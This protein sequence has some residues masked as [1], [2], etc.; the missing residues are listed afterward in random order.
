MVN[1]KVLAEL[2][3]RDDVAQWLETST[4]QLRLLLY[5]RPVAQRYKRFTLAKRR[6][7]RRAILAPPPDLK[8][9]QR[10][11]ATEL[12]KLYPLRDVVYGFA[13]GRSIIDNAKRHLRRRHVLN[14]DLS[15]FFPT[16]SYA[17]VQGLF[18]SLGASR[19]AAT[20]L[21]HICCHENALPQGAPT[22]PILSNMICAM[23]DRELLAFAK[24]YHCSYTRY[25]DDL[26]F[27]KKTGAFPLEL[28]RLDEDDRRTILGKELRA[29]IEDNG[30]TPN[31]KKIWLFS[32]VF[33]QMVTGLVVN[34]KI[35]VRREWVRQLRAMIHA[36]KVHGL[37]AAQA[38][39]RSKYYK[40]QKL[41]A[42][43]AIFVDVV[44]GKMEFLKMVKGVGDPVY[45]GLQRRLVEAQPEYI[46]IM[47]KENAQM[48]HRDV[49]ISHASED[50]E[51]VAKELAD[52]LIA[53]GV[54]V[55]YDEYSVQLGD[56]LLEKIDEGLVNSQFGVIIFS[57][58]FF[59]AKK[60]WTKREYSGLIAGED[61]DKQKRIIP[62]WH[63]ITREELYKKS[64]TIANRL[65]LL[66]SSLSV[67]QIAKK[68]AER[69][70]K[71][72]DR[73]PA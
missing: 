51:A 38:E 60:T 30:F 26:T 65:A 58:K 2:T 59:A 44:R 66:T 67:A 50:K 52:L 57:P 24:Q 35:N 69:V 21:A 70:R 54:S 8:F 17:R 48:L 15:D 31:P 47:Q 9:L 37:E 72:V 36:W 11:L 16:I 18:I 46:S 55:W 4:G 29:I 71:G 23:M 61:V 73:P 34:K 62:V 56:D 40:G 12:V 10:K 20:T 45:R 7:G 6:G 5:G 33:R 49:F 53:E 43:P 22:S 13:A 28:A 25:V 41:G 63:E 14:V 68:I 39:Y 3:S 42:K 32:R 19:D 64:P 27:S 1:A